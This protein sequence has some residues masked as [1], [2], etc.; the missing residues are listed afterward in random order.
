MIQFLSLRK[1]SEGSGD[2]LQVHIN[3]EKTKQLDFKAGDSFGFLGFEFGR[4]K[5]PTNKWREFGYVKDWLTKKIRRHIMKA[6][7]RQGFGWTLWST[8][9]LYRQDRL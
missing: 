9:E 2:T 3:E 4:Q 1:L 7:G 8:K 6:K 5:T